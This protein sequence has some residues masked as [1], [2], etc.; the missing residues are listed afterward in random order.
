MKELCMKK[1]LVLGIILTFHLALGLS[2]VYSQNISS[3]PTGYHA[4]NQ[5]RHNGK[6]YNFYGWQEKRYTIR[7]QFIVTGDPWIHSEY[8][9]WQFGKTGWSEW[10]KLGDPTP[11]PVG[12]NSHSLLQEIESLPIHQFDNSGIL[13]RNNNASN[14]R[15]TKWDGSTLHLMTYLYRP[16]S[17]APTNVSAT[18]QSSTSII[19]S[20]SAVSEATE[21]QVFRNTTSPGTFPHIRTVTGTS[22]TDT[23]LSPNTTYYYFVHSANS[24]GRGG[25][26]STVSA[27]THSGSTQNVTPQSTSQQFPSGF[28]GTWKRDNFSNT[29]TF[30]AN[31][32]KS[33]SQ[34]T[35][36]TLQRVSGD[37]YTYTPSSLPGLTIRLVN[38]NLVISGDS[39]TSENN[40][41]GI[42]IKQ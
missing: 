17:P 25:Q 3:G 35:I 15:E 36:R 27:T 26:S 20:W 23:G 18:A 16:A 29:L 28:I 13:V 9:F 41:N 4:V 11:A 37:L 8:R 7:R 10:Q 42:W 32:F 38:G 40:W 19:I 6:D 31:T 2:S 21:Y 33:S 5:V 14:Q 30:T 34:D 22:F 12:Y 39:G 24:A 1:K